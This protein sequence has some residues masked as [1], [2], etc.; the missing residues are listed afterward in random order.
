[1]ISFVR[2]RGLNPFVSISVPIIITTIPGENFIL[3]LL[4]Y[5]IDDQKV[6]STIKKLKCHFH[7]LFAFFCQ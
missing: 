6:I 2:Y 3:T 1:M 7:F 4:T 5:I